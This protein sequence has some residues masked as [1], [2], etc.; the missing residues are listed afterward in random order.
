M[1]RRILYFDIETCDAD[2]MYTLPPE[3]MFRLGGYRWAGDTEVT[4]TDD[5]EEMRRVIL[6]ADMVIGHNVISFDLPVIF[7]VKSDIPL[8]LAMERRVFD[9]WTFA[10]MV[11]P[12]PFKYINRFG[13]WAFADSPARAKKWFKLDEQAYQLGTARKTMDLGDLAMEFGDPELKGKEKQKSGFGRIPLDD[14]RYR[15]YLVGDVVT[16]EE[17]SDALL[18]PVLDRK[19]VV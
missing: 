19:S 12:A 4:L 5:L 9:T 3:E 18:A 7:G 13:E 11:H 17:V 14:K 15:A 2:L 8:R 10:V 16:T 6:E 1:A